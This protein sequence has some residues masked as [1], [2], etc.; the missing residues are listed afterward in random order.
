MTGHNGRNRQYF[1]IRSTPAGQELPNFKSQEVTAYKK[2]DREKNIGRGALRSL[3]VKISFLKE[4]Y[5]IGSKQ[6]LIFFQN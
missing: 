3:K 5:H 4:F 2:N 1:H 6:V